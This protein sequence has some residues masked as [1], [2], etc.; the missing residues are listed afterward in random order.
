MSRML[1]RFLDCEGLSMAEC[2]AYGTVLAERQRDVLFHTGDLA[3]YAQA[4]WPDHWQQV[5]PEWASPGTVTRPAG[6]CKAYPAE[7]DRQHE[8][9]Y[10]QYMQNSGKPDRQERLVAIASKGLTT[11]ESRKADQAE[12]ANDKRPGWLLVFDVHYYIHKWYHSGEKIET[13]TN[14]SE[15]AKR[16]VERLQEKGVSDVAFAFEGRGSFRKELTAGEGWEDHRYKGKRGPKDDELVNQ[17]ILTREKLTEMGYLCVSVDGYEADDVMASYAAQFPG[18]VTLIAVDK[19]L[20]QCLVQ[21]ECNMLPDID[22]KEDESTG[23]MMPIY[24][25][26]NVE[27]H[28]KETGI[29]PAQWPDYQ[30]IM[31]DNTDS[32]QGAE[33]IG[34]KIAADLI[35][36]FDTVEKAIEAAKEGTELLTEKKRQAMIE[37]EPR[38][39]VT[40]QLVTMKTDLELPRNTRI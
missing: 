5:F 16:T 6:V 24:N 7:A 12:R 39:E 26:L 25:W 23:E 22:W 11:D 2:E 9:T 36:E 30:S 17:I 10:S 14:V 33:G 19:D 40:R 15:W 4:Q 34:K 18:I 21:W 28:T 3:R 27:K 32:I 38:L 29:T 20:R 8:C 31:G 1:K 35:K 13:A 37:F